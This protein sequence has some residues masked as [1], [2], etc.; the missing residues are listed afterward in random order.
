MNVTRG[1]ELSQ[2]PNLKTAKEFRIYR[3]NLPHWEIPGNAYFISFNTTSG[4][5]LVDEAKDI[6]LNAIKFHQ[7][8]KYELYACVVMTTHVHIII[9][10]LEESAGSFFSLAQIMHSIKSYSANQIQSTLGKNGNIWLDENY[11]R[12]IRDDNDFYEKMNYIMNNPVKTGIF[13][14]P[15][16]YKWLFYQGFD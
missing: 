11:D 10:P 9:M 6:A 5:I 4:F 8:K 2:N 15:E 7:G 14:K 12:I 16:D 3:R 1:Q 13:E